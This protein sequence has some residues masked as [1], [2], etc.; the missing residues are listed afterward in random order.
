MLTKMFIY[1]DE[2]KNAYFIYAHMHLNKLYIQTHLPICL[3]KSK[4]LNK[5][6]LSNFWLFVFNQD[7]EIKNLNLQKIGIQL[8][9]SD[10]KLT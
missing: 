3:S 2:N 5:K 10:K 6:Q 9:K 7:S 1:A 8:S 4:H